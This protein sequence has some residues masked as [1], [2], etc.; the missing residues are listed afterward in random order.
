MSLRGIARQ[1]AYRLGALSAVH[2]ARNR[3]FLTVVMFHRVQSAVERL[4]TG[5]DPHYTVT[6]EFL[7]ECRSFFESHYN[8]VCLD[9]VLSSY[10]R[11]KVLP[12]FPLLITFDDGWRDNLDWALPVLRGCPWVVFAATDGIEQA[13]VWWQEAL[14]W[15]IRSGQ[16]APQ[17]FLRQ[18]SDIDTQDARYG[19]LP[20]ELRLTLEC[21]LLPPERRKTVLRPL[22][23]LLASRDDRPSMLSAQEL[24]YLEE[25][26]VSIGCHG[27]SHLP[28]THVQDAANDIARARDWLSG[29][30]EP[31]TVRAMSFPH[32]RWTS[33]LAG[34]ALQM[35]FE[36]LFTSDPVLN[37]CPSGWLQQ[38]VLG[39]IPI[40]EEAVSDPRGAFAQARMATWLYTRQKQALS[41]SANA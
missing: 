22:S 3:D 15:A 4:R 26:G 9:D 24:R 5:A 32:G 37:P 21:A 11:A 10:R 40:T 38:P 8:V 31:E 27:A 36:L 39:R 1:L 12:P 14:L 25:A 17:D 19:D 13:G 33:E 2:R 7:A 23:E 16:I 34:T 20:V 41:T 18:I 28:L 6:P 29:V 35:G 30:L